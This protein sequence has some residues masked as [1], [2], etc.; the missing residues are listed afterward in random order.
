M[1]ACNSAV[2]AQDKS[3]KPAGYPTRPIRLMVTVAPGAGTDAIAREVAQMLTAQ[4][5]QNVV[6]DNRPGGGGVIATELV[7]RA[8]PDGYT[9]IMQGDTMMLLGAT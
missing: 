6:V 5:G 4:F 8:A 7:A 9:I 3:D 1:F 2:I